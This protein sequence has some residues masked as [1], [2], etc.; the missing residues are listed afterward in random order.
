MWFVAGAFAAEPTHTGV[1]VRLAPGSPP[2]SALEV[3]CD[4]A[5]RARVDFV[6]GLAMSGDLSHDR[7]R[8]YFRGGPPA[9]AVVHRGDQLECGFLEGVADC[10][11]VGLAPPAGASAAPFAQPPPEPPPTITLS[12]SSPRYTQVAVRCGAFKSTASVVDGV[13]TIAGLP[14]EPCEATFSA[15]KSLV[16]TT[17]GGSSACDLPTGRCVAGTEPPG[18]PS[19]SVRIEVPAE[20]PPFY[21]VEVTCPSGFRDRAEFVDHA[22][23]VAGVPLG[24]QCRA[25]LKGGPPVA[26]RLK[27]AADLTCRV[28]G[29]QLLCG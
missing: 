2:Y 18:P 20:G 7:C 25:M 22:A 1:V 27:G 11:V 15:P 8:V 17:P 23:T 3:R 24:E 6:G 4:D 19:T 21:A 10:R 5:D 28:V 26:G 12:P 13:A 16:V 9:V 14:D 29:S